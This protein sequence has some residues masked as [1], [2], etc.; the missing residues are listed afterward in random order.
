MEITTLNEDI[1]S[2]LN[3]WPEN[4]ASAAQQAC[5]PQTQS[6]QH[7]HLGIDNPD[8]LRLLAED[9]WDGEPVF[10]GAYFWNNDH[11]WPPDRDLIRLGI[12][13]QMAF[14]RTLAMVLKGQWE[15]FFEKESRIDNNGGKNREW[16]HSFQ[17]LN[18]LEALVAF[19]EEAKQL[20][21][22]FNPGYGRCA[23]AEALFD[24]FEQHKH[25]A[26][27]AGY[28]R[29]KFNTLINQ[30]I[31]AH[32]HLLGNHS[33]ELDAF[34][35]ER[36]KEQALIK[37]SSQEEQDEFWRSKLI[38]L[39]QQNILE[40]WL[41]QL[42]NQRLKNANIHQKW[43]ATFGELFYALKEKQYQVLSLQRRIQFKMT[44]P[45]LNQEA[46]EQLEQ[47]ALK[48]EHEALSHLQS[49]VVVAEL[50]QTLGTHGQSL[51][52]K[53]QAD[54]E[55]E[56]K[57]VL[58]KIHFKTHPDRLPKE[59]TQQQRQELEKYFFSVRKIN[60]KEIGLDLRSLPQL[61]GILDHVE[62]IW[63]S[64]GLDIDARQVIRGESLKDQLAWLKK[65]NLRFEQEVAEIRND[66]K[67]ICDD[68]EIREQATSLQ[69]VEPVKKGLQEQLAQYEAEAN[70]LEA[71]LASLFSS[72][73]A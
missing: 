33:P 36:H 55:R 60:P 35:A 65:E 18:L 26:T 11:R 6:L 7:K 53:E 23:N 30:M 73:A 8:C 19:P 40:N 21:L 46:L 48:E 63:E 9:G 64:M 25:A 44:N 28:D 22:E 4:E 52:P 67:F 45:K 39:E 12:F 16:A 42:E 1:D 29:A 59:F 32:A 38:W 57:R 43:A 41:L 62:A 69:S 54:Y 14:E 56:V 72:E 37:D 70:K 50:L 20:S 27:E 58:L 34:I 2:L 47:E 13:F 24:L 49:E 15:R 31:M 10:S 51:N 61:L 3:R 17:Q 71:E 66:L 5:W 68:P